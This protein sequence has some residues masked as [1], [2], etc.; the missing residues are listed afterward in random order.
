M[1][2]REVDEFLKKSF[3]E[4]KLESPF[5]DKIDNLMSSLYKEKKKKKYVDYNSNYINFNHS[6]FN[7][8]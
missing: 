7:F 5:H 6:I 1:K 2:Y 3:S 8:N 4:E